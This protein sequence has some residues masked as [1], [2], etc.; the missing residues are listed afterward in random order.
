MKKEIL[1]T[2]LGLV[3]L[4]FYYFFK[5]IQSGI[6]IE[7]NFFLSFNYTT[8]PEYWHK[9]TNSLNFFFN[10]YQGSNLLI[11][12]PD[13]FFYQIFGFDKLW[14][15]AIL[16]KTIL[17]LILI[18][19]VQKKFKLKNNY[20]ILWI[21]IVVVS[22]SSSYGFF[23]DRLL[24]NS[25]TIIF[26]AL[27]FINLYFLTKKDEISNL[28]SM[29]LG[30]STAILLSSDPWSLLFLVPLYL[31]NFRKL[32]KSLHYLGF[33]FLFMLPAIYVFIGQQIH[34]YN[35]ADYLGTKIIFDKNSFYID[36]L[37]DLAKNKIIIV[38]LIFNFLIN[39]Y[40]KSNYRTLF[41]V[42]SLTAPPLIL[43]LFNFTIQSYHLREGAINLSI[44]CTYFFLLEFL[45]KNKFTFMNNKFFLII[46]I[47]F[48][49]LYLYFLI[50]RPNHWV[51]RTVQIKKSYE[52][53]FKKI[54]LLNK[55]CIIISNDPY[56]SGYA[57]LLK[58]KILPED[59]FF[60]NNYIT[61]SI[62]EVKFLSF[63]LKIKQED[64]LLSFYWRATGALFFNTRST[65]SKYV[66]YSSQ[67]FYNKL[68]K[69][70]TMELWTITVP[71]KYLNFNNIKEYV[72]LNNFEYIKF[73]ENLK[74]FIYLENNKTIAKSD[75][76]GLQEVLK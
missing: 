2:I 57:K 49:S 13:F 29:I 25:L 40:N 56:I 58:F 15:T 43:I 48:T 52:Q 46:I 42:F 31:I 30:G 1:F 27:I 67:D 64:V 76:C 3:L 75:K 24:R 7:K 74:N 65:N 55:D 36:W 47:F 38:L 45:L 69:I 51:E 33:F 28:N 50:I 53:D 34:E 61:D 59:S 21:A 54:S 5:F 35:N 71:E 70:N 4:Y 63:F 9:V 62:A 19:T 66:N 14:I 23:V 73:T 68:S 26:Y 41:L 16:Y 22:L 39:F 20:H 11:Q 44:F 12:L 6:L 10:K 17:Y 32:L 37:F 60:R 72:N 18:L 8:A